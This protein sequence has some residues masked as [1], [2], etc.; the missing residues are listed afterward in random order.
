[1]NI[2][3]HESQELFEILLQKSLIGNFIIQDGRLVYFNEAVEKVTGYSFEE[4]RDLDPF[5]L[6]HPE[7]RSF[8]YQKYLLRING[9][10][11]DETYS[12]RIITKNGAV[13]WITARA[14]GV[15]YKGKPGV[16]V[17]AMDTTPLIELTEKLRKKNELLSHLSSIL[18]HDILSDLAIISA[19][20]ELR[21][22]RLLDRAF[23]RIKKIEEKIE[24]VKR[25]EEEMGEL[26]VVNVA[27]LAR[28]AVEKYRRDADINFK[29]ENVF[30]MAN[31]SLKSAIE[32]ILNNAVIHNPSRVNIEVN[33][34]RDGKDCVVRI[35]DNGVGIDDE[36]KKKLFNE[37]ISTRKGGGLGLLIVKKII[38]TFRGSI[39][40]YDNVPRGAVF[41]IRIPSVWF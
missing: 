10:S 35:S 33:V 37:R 9:L 23:E 3:N 11:E 25:L 6:V 15:N 34:F 7:D 31:E 1:M 8:V 18:R 12:F 24:D 22:E 5:E 20:I 16:A 36:I 19:A 39:K 14:L 40:V 17:N 2:Y 30:A 27:E 28:D 26:K 29:H 4:L 41:E 13:R 38:E 21:D 32:N